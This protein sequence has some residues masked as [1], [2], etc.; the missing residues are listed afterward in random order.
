MLDEPWFSDRATRLIH[1]QRVYAELAEI[2]AERT[3]S[4]WLELCE[5]EGIPAN[6]VPSSRRSSPMRRC[7]A[8]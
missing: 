6:P 3:T 5:R 1:A 2:A 4:E 8:A 7:T